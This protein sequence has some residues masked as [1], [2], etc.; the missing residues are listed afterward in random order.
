[1]AQERREQCNEKSCGHR[2]SSHNDATVQ[3]ECMEC[4]CQAF[5]YKLGDLPRQRTPDEAI[6]GYVQAEKVA[7]ER[8]ELKQLRAKVEVYEKRFETHEITIRQLRADMVNATGTIKAQEL[9][10][11]V[12]EKV[13]TE[14]KTELG[15]T[16]FLL[17]MMVDTGA[18]PESFAKTFMPTMPMVG[19]DDEHGYFEGETG[20]VAVAIILD[21]DPDYRI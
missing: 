18:L 11:E 4:T 14:L 9:A 17:S 21:E 20:P 6:P 13:I 16:R 8:A 2:R 10:H 19:E 15:G 1:M 12:A 3:H 5:E 7:A